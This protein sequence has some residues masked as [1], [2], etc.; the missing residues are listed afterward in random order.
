MEPHSKAPKPGK[1]EN[2]STEEADFALRHPLALR[3]PL[4]GVS[5]ALQRLSPHSSLLGLETL[6]RVL[7]PSCCRCCSCCCWW[8]LGFSCQVAS[9]EGLLLCRV[10]LQM[11]VRGLGL[12]SRSLLYMEPCACRASQHCLQAPTL[13][14]PSRPSER[15]PNHL[16]H[17]PEGRWAFPHSIG[18]RAS[19]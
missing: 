19:E 4:P 12:Q 16:N 1:P 2:A 3:S 9:N 13:T 17:V 11:R 6:R 7:H 10:V 5:V 8:W 14:E 15:I 18:R